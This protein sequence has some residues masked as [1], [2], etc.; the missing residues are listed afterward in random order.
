MALNA[1]ITIIYRLQSSQ[2]TANELFSAETA[3]KSL[4]TF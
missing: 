2:F 1:T 4:E 3:G